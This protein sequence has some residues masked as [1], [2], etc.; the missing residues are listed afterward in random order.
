MPPISP[1]P[2]EE[3]VVEKSQ[4]EKN[5]ADPD[6]QEQLQELD[7]LNDWIDKTRAAPA[8]SWRCKNCGEDNPGNFEVCWNCPKEK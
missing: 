5:A 3:I 6:Y 4:A 2:R 1:G 7:E 8:P